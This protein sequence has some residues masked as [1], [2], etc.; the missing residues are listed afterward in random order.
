MRVDVVTTGPLVF[1]DGSPVRAASGLVAYGG[2]WLVVQDDSTHV[3]LLKA[4]SV[5]RLRVLPPVEGHDEFSEQAGTKQL[6]P[7]LEGAVETAT[8]AL[9]VGSGS[10]DA[11]MRWVELAPGRVPQVRDRSE[12]YAE[13]GSAL[14]VAPENLNI[15]G[16]CREGGFLR[17]FQRG[18][19]SAGAPTGSVRVDPGSGRV[20]DVRHYDLGEVDGV[21]LA[22]TDAV[23]IGDG[24]VL[25]SAAAEDSPTTYD[26]GPVVGSA[27]ALLDGADVVASAVLPEAAKVEG[28]AVL[29]WSSSGGR[30]LAVVDADDPEEPSRLLTLEISLD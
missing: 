23:S 6:K 14:G 25:V 4:G 29:Q 26:D 15:E 18:L 8:G 11:R 9:L 27:L 7:D 13:I 20:S 5:T 3:A 28:L 19:P 12:W 24:P 10:S 16:V 22:V 21:G 2:G 30:V 17:L 1:D